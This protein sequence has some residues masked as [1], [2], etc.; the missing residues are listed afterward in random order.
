[1]LD[2]IYMCGLHFSISAELM[3]LVGSVKSLRPVLESLFHRILLY[4][5][6]QQRLEALKVIR[7]VG[8]LLYAVCVDY[9]LS[10]SYFFCPPPTTTLHPPTPH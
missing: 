9:Q 8:R 3:R 6:P 5:P 2:V 7:E 4:P 1:M 10:L